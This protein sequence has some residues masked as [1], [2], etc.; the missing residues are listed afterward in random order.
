MPDILKDGA[1]FIPNVQKQKDFVQN[2]YLYGRD[3]NVYWAVVDPIKYPL[4]VWQKAGAG[5]AIAKFAMNYIESAHKLGAIVYTNGPQMELAVGTEPFG[6]VHGDLNK[7]DDAG[8]THVDKLLFLFGRKKQTGGKVKF[9]DYVITSCDNTKNSKI[10]ISPYAEV[11]TM[12]VPLIEK[13]KAFSAKDTGT[14]SN[15]NE[16]FRDL[17][18]SEMLAAW[19]LVGPPIC[20]G[21]IIALGCNAGNQFQQIVDAL[22]AVGVDAAVGMDGHTSVMIGE[23]ANS[24][25]DPVAAKQAWQKYG[26]Y[27]I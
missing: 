6:P 16:A 9:S 24:W 27:C 15:Y 19:A 17:L 14:T 26:F 23:R 3:N 8:A 11:I 10:D 25:I 4:Y 22:V 13:K 12:L 2:Q 21:L 18:N 20:D 5:G 1:N 7:I